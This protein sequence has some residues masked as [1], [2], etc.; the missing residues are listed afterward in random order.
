LATVRPEE[1]RHRPRLFIEQFF[2][3]LCD[4][5]RA[6]AGVR[7]AGLS[8]KLTAPPMVAIMTGV[9]RRRSSK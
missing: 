1:N 6:L 8:R 2:G 3:R 5:L 7:G 4:R 9:Q